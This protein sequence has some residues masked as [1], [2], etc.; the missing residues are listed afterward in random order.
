MVKRTLT[1]FAPPVLSDSIASPPSP[2]HKGKKRNP[3]RRQR[4]NAWR[5]CVLWL[6]D[7][8]G[9]SCTIKRCCH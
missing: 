1:P 6:Y 3:A 9:C 4:R 8:K 7:Y 2:Y 5:G